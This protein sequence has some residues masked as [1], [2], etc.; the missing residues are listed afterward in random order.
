MSVRRPRVGDSMKLVSGEPQKIDGATIT[1]EGAGRDATV[2]RAS[3]R[4]R[5]RGA[6]G[7]DPVYDLLGVSGFRVATTVEI[8]PGQMPAEVGRGGPGRVQPRL[9]LD[10]PLLA[11]DERCHVLLVEEDGEFRWVFAEPGTKRFELDVEPARPADRGALGTA[12]RKIVTFLAVKAAKPVAQAAVRSLARAA[13]DR[14]HRSRVRTFSGADFRMKDAGEPDVHLL[15][16]GP[17]LL[18]LHGTNSLSHTGFGRLD[19]TFVDGVNLSYGGRVFAFDHPTLAVEPTENARV[20]T[21]WVTA[22]LPAG[23]RLEL[24]VLAHSRGGLVARELAERPIDKRIAVRSVVFVAT[25]NSGTPLCDGEHLGELVDALTNLAAV[26]PDNPI[27]DALEIVFEL[28]KDIALDIAYDALPGVQA[29]KPGSDYLAQLNASARTTATYRALAADFE[30]VSSAGLLTKLRN[31][32]FDKVFNGS[33]NDLIVPTRSAYLTSGGF[34]VSP[35]QR[36][37]FDSSYGIN[38][39]TFWTESRAVERLHDWLRPDWPDHLPSPTDAATA[40]VR[41]DVESALAHADTRG[42]LDAAAVITSLPQK[43]ADAAGQVLGGPVL[44]PP[45]RGGRGAVVVI[46]G[47]M[48]SLLDLDGRRVWTSPAALYSGGF[49]ELRL[50]KTLGAVT[51]V[52]LNP[53]YA[54]LVAT[55]AQTW[56]VYL[57]PFDWRDDIGA[58]AT[59]LDEFVRT[60]VFSGGS[61]R[62]THV[63][64]HSMGGLVARAFI[65]RFAMTWTDMDDAAGEHRRG[66]RLVMLGTPNRGSYAIPLALVGEDLL[67]KVLAA[68]DRTNTRRKIAAIMATFPGMYQ[69]LP[70]PG[71]KVD[72]DH[73]L[74][75]DAKTWGKVND[76]VDPALLERASR[77]HAAL[78]AGGD[79]GRL[80]YVA[81][82]GHLTPARISVSG[83]TFTFG[84]HDRGDGRV[85]HESGL[86]TGNNY[87]SRAKHGDLVTDAAVLAALPDLLTS[88]KT[89]R[90]DD[91][92]AAR[93]GGAVAVAVGPYVPADQVD[94]DPVGALVRGGGDRPTAADLRD[95]VAQATSLYLGT[96]DQTADPGALTQLRVRVSHGSLEQAD[97]PVMVGHY[98]GIPPEGAEAFLD[99]KLSGALDRHR[100]LGDYPEAVGDALYVHDPGCQPPGGIVLGLGEFGELSRSKLVRAVHRAAVQR[101]LRAAESGLA[102]G[103]GTSVG[104]S[105]VLVSTPGQYGL[106]VDAS[107]SALVEGVARAAREL[108][109]LDSSIAV[110]LDELEIIEL[111]ESRA[112]EAVLAARGVRALIPREV[113]D[114]LDLRLPDTL[115]IK[116]GG[117]PGSPLSG[118]SGAPWPRIVVEHRLPP[119]PPCDHEGASVAPCGADR[120]PIPVVMLPQLEF[121]RLGRGAQVDRLAVHYDEVKVRSIIDAASTRPDA[122]AEG[123]ALFEL[124]F[125]HEEKLVVNDSDSLHLLVDEDTATI[126]WELV[127]GR[128]SG[129]VDDAFALR[130]GMLR[131]LRPTRTGEPVRRSGRPPIDRKALVVGNP[132][133]EYGPLPG[134]RREAEEVADLLE[135][136]GYAVERVIFDDDDQRDDGWLRVQTALVAQPYRVVHFATH[137]VVDAER[138]ERSGLMIGNGVRLTAIDFQQMSVTPDL[139][140]L[141]AC[142]VGRMGAAPDAPK[143]LARANELAANIALRLMRNGVKAV[144][145]AGWAVDDRAALTFSR[146]LYREL[147]AGTPYGRSVLQARKEANDGGRTN[148]WG[149]YQCYG[150]PGFY[151]TRKAAA[152]TP[153]PPVSA[154][155]LADRINILRVRA[156]DERDDGAIGTVH[157]TLTALDRMNDQRFET[158][159]VFEALGFAYGE[160]G[161]FE[162]AVSAFLEA[163]RAD[164]GRGRMSFVAHEQL[165]NFEARFAASRKANSATVTGPTSAPVRPVKL[166]AGE[167]FVDA[168]RRLRRLVDFE[169]TEERLNLLGSLYKKRAVG[170][171]GESRARDVARAADAYRDSH[172]LHLTGSGSPSAYSSCVWLQLSRI[173]GATATKQRRDVLGQLDEENKA[174]SPRATIVE[175]DFWADTAP[176]DVAL[177]RA[178]L[179]DPKGFAV[180]EGHYLAAFRNR[181]TVRER[182]SVIEHLRDLRA[183]LPAKA[184]ATVDGML[185]RL[186]AAAS[187]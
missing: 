30:P 3:G 95:L 77:F 130:A 82:D 179:G 60:E 138:P 167:L 85:T 129:H 137:G 86:L 106:P 147:L 125:P 69:M 122:V 27:T 98:Q 117:R 68:V 48:G 64:A 120:L 33:M 153:D 158:V 155:E 154:N 51:A 58:A 109:N 5:T 107:V 81:G 42:F 152:D 63:V 31:R 132:P 90:L 187:Q 128:L 143:P 126:P 55:L 168:E 156:G 175:P 170:R 118:A 72:D 116:R 62:P 150:D 59:R 91:K 50:P 131:Q 37:V 112:T 47:I 160:L 29:M 163:E 57:F 84:S 15:G 83:G 4:S 149:A 28:V 185:E 41:A 171:S 145:A 113:L 14:L 45:A 32:L 157:R 174:R 178:V 53:V 94:P 103:P 25:P 74:L 186:E 146:A 1:F 159:I 142:H 2:N 114:S 176:G 166:G 6:G 108:A 89:T 17:A 134:A 75:Y 105:A 182:N 80:V 100:D 169:T 184:S 140:V 97:H 111:Y 123:F 88:G 93:R 73:G 119:C 61:P 71:L 104:V 172:D 139:V 67:V 87:F 141:N 79:D 173:A 52:G 115:D 110:K 10:P 38:H 54:S 44:P 70:A 65:K 124:L 148:T 66:G 56:D 161:C 76:S 181:S 121:T 127:C 78:D 36:T 26:I 11:R 92:P 35:A 180:A 49:A 96:P 164:A 162:D 24:D 19:K 151:L 16:A 133:T 7:D 22:R 13:E 12:A 135:G 9:L 21:D 144:V 43:F 136:A 177:T 39:S 46:P 8:D 101:T 18:F 165:A 102:V 183:L 34:T 99:R 23:S 40:D 20:F